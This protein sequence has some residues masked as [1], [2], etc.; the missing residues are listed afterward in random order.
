M[1]N[2]ILRQRVNNVTLLS[3]SGRLRG[4]DGSTLDIGGNKTKSFTRR[5]LDGAPE[6]PDTSR[7]QD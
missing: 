6:S 5:A 3:G 1:N 2:D 4:K 7:Y